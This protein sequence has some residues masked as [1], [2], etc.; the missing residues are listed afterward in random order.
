MPDWNASKTC[1]RGML[2]SAHLLSKVTD[3][4]EQM[5]NETVKMTASRLG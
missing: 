1:G 3:S 2:L 4:A 5:W